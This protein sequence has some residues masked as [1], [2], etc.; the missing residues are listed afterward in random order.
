[1]F[2]RS[3]LQKQQVLITTCCKNNITA[4]RIDPEQDPEQDTEP[5]PEPEQ[6]HKEDKNVT[7]SY[8]AL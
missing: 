7:G 2:L 1:M 3:V 8:Y 6:R 5:D 4:K